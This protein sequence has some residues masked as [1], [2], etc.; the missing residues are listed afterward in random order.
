MITF[1]EE[2]EPQI[3]GEPGDLKFVIYTKPDK[4]FIRQGDDLWIKHNITLEDAL[5]GFSK[6]VRHPSGR[7]HSLQHPQAVT[8]LV[9]SDP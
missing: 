5:V 1:F 3:D 8:V 7:R 4:D 9:I 2:G 6:Q